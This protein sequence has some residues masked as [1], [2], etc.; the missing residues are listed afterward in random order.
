[1]III[2]KKKFFFDTKS[3]L[4]IFI[5][6]LI[7]NVLYLIIFPHEAFA[8][9][10]YDFITSDEDMISDE[11]V[12]SELIIARKEGYMSYNGICTE[13]TRWDL[14]RSLYPNGLPVDPN[15]INDSYDNEVYVDMPVTMIFGGSENINL[16]SGI[17]SGCKARSIDGLL[18]WPKRHPFH[19]EFVKDYTQIIAP[20][21]IISSVSLGTKIQGH[22]P[23]FVYIKCQDIYKHKYYWTVWER[24]HIASYWSYKAF[25]KRWDNELN[26]WSNID[27]NIRKD[28]II[29][30]K[31]LL[32]LKR[33]DK[34]IRKTIR[35][36]VQKLI[37]KTNL[38]H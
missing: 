26:I 35:T 25:K 36:E 14:F 3:L 16:S 37:L 18:I 22:H 9:D 5:L 1:M 29:E 8:M 10:P 38:S 27:E 23:V 34:N 7:F 13:N 31:D 20:N 33:V 12:R 24:T 17:Y 15:I 6:F 32:S 21:N 4:L 11:E 30:V 19:V 28:I 2:T